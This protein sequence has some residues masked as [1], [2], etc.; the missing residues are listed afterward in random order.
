MGLLRDIHTAWARL[1]DARNPRFTRFTHRLP[2]FPLPER[3]ALPDPPPQVAILTPCRDA[4]PVLE[5]YARLI[6]SLDY[7][8]DRL[9]WIVLEGDSADDTRARARAMLDAAPGH[10]ATRLIEYDLGTTTAGDRH[11]AGVQRARRARIAACRNRLLAAALDT[12]AAYLLFVDVDMAAVPPDALRRALEWRAPILVANCLSH[13]RDTVYDR[14]AF[15]YTAPVSDRSAARFVR[16]GLYQ[17]PAG[18]F[19]HYPAPCDGPGIAP[20]HSVGG[21]FLLIRRDV[22]EAGA[23]FP[24][25]PYQLHIETEGFAL[26]AADLGFGAFMAPGLIVRHGPNP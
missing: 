22:V 7:P 15:R 12:P 9:H 10:A 13:D 4:A 18:F 1:A 11:R 23:D 6:Q 14:N 8:K 19:R 16:D 17:P 3:R 25:E 5:T 20:L 26:K 2:E 21:T 24:E